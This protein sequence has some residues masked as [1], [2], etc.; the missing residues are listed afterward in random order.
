MLRLAFKDGT[1]LLGS[2]YRL[3][4]GTVEQFLLTKE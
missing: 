3:P 4:D 1:A 2:L